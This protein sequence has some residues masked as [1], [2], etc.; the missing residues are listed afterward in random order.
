MAFD[1]EE[2]GKKAAREHNNQTRVGEMNP[3]FSPIPVKS[4]RVRGDQIDKEDRANEMPAGENRKLEM[5]SIRRPPNKE[6]LKVS[7]LGLVNSEMNLGQRASKDE[8]HCRCQTNHCQLKRRKK[9]NPSVPHQISSQ[10]A[11]SRGN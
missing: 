8:R 9:V 4:P 2:I 6:T 7:R 3:K 1:C 10:I 5:I 11:W